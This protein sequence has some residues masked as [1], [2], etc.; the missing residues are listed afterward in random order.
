[1]GVS[2]VY[3]N[4]SSGEMVLH[5]NSTAMTI[6]TVNVVHLARL[7]SAGH[8]SGMSFN[9]GST[10]AITAY[11]DGG[12]GQVVVTSA[13]HGL[14]NGANL[15]ISGT[16]NYNGVFVIS[17]VTVNTFEITDTWVANDAT[18]TFNEGSNLI[19]SETG[20][21]VATWH[22]SMISASTN[23][24][25]EFHIFKNGLELPHT[26]VDVQLTNK[27]MGLG[28]SNIDDLGSGDVMTFGVE[29]ITDATNLTII[30]AAI[31]LHRIG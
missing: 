15:S 31:A 22:G 12:G 16:T 20:S 5:E 17:A 4:R 3:G 27:N 11:A 13:G 25:Y 2:S 7:F 23:K 19:I 14:S 1:M 28:A 9:P 18:G 30:S 10:G 8:S 26:H 6:D 29:G 24:D 21:Y